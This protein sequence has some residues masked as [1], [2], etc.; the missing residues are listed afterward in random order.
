MRV[1]LVTCRVLPEPDPDQSLL[2]AALKAK[3]LAAELVVWD[4]PAA[5]W[6][7]FDLCVIRSTWD[8]FHRHDD[9]I[10]WAERAGAATR[11]CNPAPIVRWNAHKA[12]LGDLER[13]G[14]PIV[15]TLSLLRGRSVRLGE[16]MARHGWEAVVVKPAVSAGSFETLRVSRESLEDGEGHLL[17]LLATRDVLV[18]PYLS[19]VEGYVDARSC[20]STASSP[21]PSASRRASVPIPSQS[22]KRSPSPPL[23]EPLPPVPSLP[24]PARPLSSMRAST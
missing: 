7:S 22:R 6:P 24:S 18:Q 16:I 12:Y 5:A 14:V 23:S 1:A 13:R 10:A 21:T 2:V 8:Y 4:D 17:R 19:S 15:P 9:F 11:L 3:G 20:A